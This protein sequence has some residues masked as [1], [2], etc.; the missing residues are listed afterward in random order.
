VEV[1][2]DRYRSLVDALLDS[3]A[4]TGFCYTQLTDTV[5]EQNGLVTEDREPKVPVERIRAINCRTAASVPADA[6]G[7][8]EYGDYPQ[9]LDRRA[10]HRPAQ[11]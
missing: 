4:V 3:P 1:F 7:E 10:E 8:F 5:Q 2:V 11:T 6:V 9:P